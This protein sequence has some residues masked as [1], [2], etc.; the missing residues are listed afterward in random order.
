[1]SHGGSLHS[2]RREVAPGLQLETRL[3]H[4]E[5]DLLQNGQW[6]LRYEELQFGARLAWRQAERCV[7][8]LYWQSLETDASCPPQKT[9]PTPCSNTCALPSTEVTFSPPFPS[10]IL[11]MPKG[12][13]HDLEFPTPALCR[14]SQ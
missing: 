13:H 1:M 8:R 9:S 10:L 5:Q 3:Q 11:V 12:Q 4:V 2:F 6:Q 14:L 7:G